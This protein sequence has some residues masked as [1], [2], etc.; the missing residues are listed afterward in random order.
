VATATSARC[1]PGAPRSAAANASAKVCWPGLG[2]GYQRLTAAAAQSGVRSRWHWLQA[3][4]VPRL[5]V[6]SGRGMRK[7]WSWR[8]STT[9]YVVVGMWQAAHSAPAEPGRWW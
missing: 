3:F 4:G 6:R 5:A 9:M 2:C 1:A 8:G 7:P